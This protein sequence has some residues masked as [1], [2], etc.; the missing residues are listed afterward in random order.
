M[1]VSIEASASMKWHQPEWEVD[2]MASL[3]RSRKSVQRRKVNRPRFC[4]L[5]RYPDGSR[6]LVIRQVLSK[7]R[8]QVDGYTLTERGAD[9]GRGFQL[10]KPDG[11]RY[12]VNVLSE[13]ESCECPGLLQHGHRPVCK[14]RAS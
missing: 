3:T 6:A 10:T 8:E 7:N 9:C 14:H 13:H 4:K 1:G 12:A 2:A 11:T 5:V